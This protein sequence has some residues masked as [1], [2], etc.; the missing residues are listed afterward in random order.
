MKACQSLPEGYGP[1]FEIDLMK[2]RKAL[3]TV[4]VASL[5][6]ALAMLI[7][8]FVFIPSGTDSGQDTFRAMFGRLLVLVAGY[9][10]YVILH[11]LTHAAVMRL[12]GGREVRFGFNVQYAYAGSE[13]DYFDKTAYLLIALTPLVL[14]G[15]VF[16]ALQCL[17]PPAWA[18]TVWLF[19]IGNVSGAAGDVYVVWRLRHMPRTVLVRD[20]GLKMTVYSEQNGA[21]S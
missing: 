6:V 8:M 14:W 19:Q 21:P 15:A 5:A 4:A 11:E 18:R 12:A 3:R 7:V 13:K 20:T 17:V 16:M 10:A 2:D 9:L 1:A